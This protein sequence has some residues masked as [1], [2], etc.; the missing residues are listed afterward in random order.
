MNCHNCGAPMKPV[1]NRAYLHCEYCEAYHFPTENNDGV[2]LLGEQ[3]HLVCP[4]CGIP[5]VS[6]KIQN[7]Y[8][9]HC[10]Q[11]RGVLV[12]QIAFVEIVKRLRASGFTDESVLPDSIQPEEFS[13]EI[14]CPAC[15]Q[16]MEA[17]LYLGPGNFVIDDCIHCQLNWLDYGEFN[18]IRSA[19]GRDRALK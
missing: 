16:K 11:C 15:E 10:A 1:P 17:H 4:I 5:L 12:N 14:L 19:P 3:G 8:V 2:I 7:L 18:L 9:N 13:R 6:A